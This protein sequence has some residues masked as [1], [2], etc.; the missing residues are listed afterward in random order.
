MKNG[1]KQKVIIVMPAY[2]VATILPKT[3]SELPKEGI[4][5]IIVV[6][7]GSRDNTSGVAK[8][9][10]LTV[11]R[12][13]KNRG[14]G[15]AQKTGYKAAIERNADIV[16][17]IHGDDQYD[18]SLASQFI[19]KINDEGFEVVTGTRMVLGDPI[20]EGMPLWKYIAN[21]F[22]TRLE[23]I[24]FNTNLTDYHN[25]FRAYSV[26]FLKKVPFDLFSDRFDFDTDII[27][28]A[29]IRK[30]KIAEIPNPIRYRDENSQ[31]PF[32]KGVQYGL[33]ILKTLVKY[34]LHKAG[35]KNKLFME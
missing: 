1:Y 10:G 18:P 26:D 28:Q 27:I 3:W 22:L 13:S 8:S 32:F 15:G 35:I 16:V 23:N 20:R 29:A 25:G 6:D 31:M 2:N 5:E 4:D 9:L 33:A 30:Y 12:H 19:S 24:V 7:D 14:Y 34:W 17:M 21:R 11:I